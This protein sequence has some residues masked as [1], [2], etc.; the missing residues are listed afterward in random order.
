MID[1]N[2]ALLFIHS[3]VGDDDEGKTFTPEEYEQ[4]KKRVLPM[5]SS[6]FKE[7]FDSK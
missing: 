4:Y 6:R 3:I 7:N 2:F 5:V 1:L